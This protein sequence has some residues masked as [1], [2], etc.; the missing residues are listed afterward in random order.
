M[1]LRLWLQDG[2][3]LVFS[4]PDQIAAAV[5]RSG[6]GS[7]PLRRVQFFN[8]QMLNYLFTIG[9]WCEDFRYTHSCSANPDCDFL[10]D[11]LLAKSLGL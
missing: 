1:S 4:A 7:Q 10:N 3:K 9:E 6:F 2:R 11:D 8:A 5:R